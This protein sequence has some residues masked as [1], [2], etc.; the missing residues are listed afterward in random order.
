LVCDENRLAFARSFL[1]LNRFM[2]PCPPLV[3]L[4][5]DRIAPA[6][7]IGHNTVTYQDADGDLVTL[8][9]SKPLLTTVNVDSVLKFDT[10]T[11]SQS[12]AAK[13]Q[14]QLVDLT[15]F[16]NATGLSL[17]VTA[18]K[19]DPAGNGRADVGY[20]KAGTFD[21]TAVTDGFDLGTVSIMG[22]LGRIDA[23]DDDTAPALAA[24]KVLSIGERGTGTQVTTGA[25]LSSHIQGPATSISVAGNVNQATLN[26]LPV[27]GSPSSGSIG[28]LNIA[29]SLI[30]GA[31]ADSGQ[32]NFTGTINRATIGSIDG[33][34]G[35]RSGAILG[36]YDT[37]SKINSLTVTG[38]GTGAAKKGITGGTAQD[39]GEVAASKISSISV[40]ADVKGGS[41]L[42]SGVIQADNLGRVSITGS[43]IGGSAI[44]SGEIFAGVIGSV[45]IGGDVQGGTAGTA[46]AQG[47]S[48]VISSATNVGSIKI[49]GSLIGGNFLD[50]THTASLSG[51]ITIKGNIGSLTIGNG[52]VGTGNVTGGTGASSGFILAEGTLGTTRILGNFTGADSTATQKVVNSAY[53]Q[54]A[55]I[56]SLFIGGNVTAGDNLGGGID[57]SGAIRST[58][59]IGALTIKGNLTGHASN[60]AIISAVGQEDVADKATADMA[61]RSVMISGNMERAEI[62]AGYNTDTTGQTITRGTPVNGDASIGAVRIGKDMIAS[63]IVAGIAPGSD[64]FFGDSNDAAI[65]G[66]GKLN[67]AN[68]I[69]K[70]SS[71]IIAGKGSGTAAADNGHFGIVAQQVVSV[72]VSNKA[73]ALTAEASNDI[74]TTSAATDKSKPI[75]DTT[76]TNTGTSDTHDFHIAE[77]LQVVNA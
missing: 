2:P 10:G 53:I 66:A 12:N 37:F 77:V 7:L 15:Q 33:D 45:S 8:K 30:G 36:S 62:L 63:D 14:L 68:L 67:R 38:L 69:S 26:I 60:P 9:I 41:G 21:G 18:K 43:L 57:T 50:A 35:A 24:L 47:N 55:H 16:D 54:A 61:I 32:V 25:S 42:I 70:I 4:L 72:K 11:V 51:A 6:T 19:V 34:G 56:P 3:E 28:T 75:G 20:V 5:E 13:Q 58:H 39:T 73:I 52:K 46:A 31:A 1:A 29:G 71:I 44:S 74:A 59:E 27:S 64:G 23:G 22:D 65:S 49:G 48:G 17:T 76:G 40:S